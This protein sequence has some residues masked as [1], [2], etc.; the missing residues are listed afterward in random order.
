MTR[1]NKRRMDSRRRHRKLLWIFFGASIV[2][3][4]LYWEQ[5][6]LL[7]VISTLAICGLMLIV[8]FANLEKKD[9]ELHQSTDD[10]PREKRDSDEREPLES[11]AA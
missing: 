2:S 5:A 8:A 4:L 6:A 3:A 7:Y 11:K 1:R 9:K 10:R